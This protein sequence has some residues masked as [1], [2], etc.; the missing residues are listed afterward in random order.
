MGLKNVWEQTNLVNRIIT[1][2]P[3]TGSLFIL[4]IWVIM[5]IVTMYH[6]VSHDYGSLCIPWLWITLYSFTNDHPVSSDNG[7]PIIQDCQ[8]GQVSQLRYVNSTTKKI[9][10]NVGG[11]VAGWFSDYIG[12]SL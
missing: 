6:P 3:A 12:T 11:W 8:L 2:N 9:G 7:P 5:V 4:S 1:P 10:L